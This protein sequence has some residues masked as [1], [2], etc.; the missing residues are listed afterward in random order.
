VFTQETG[1]IMDIPLIA[2]QLKAIRG[3]YACDCGSHE[4]YIDADATYD[5]IKPLIEH[6]LFDHVSPRNILMI[7]HT[8]AFHAT[9]IDDI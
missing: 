2:R 1:A 4:T 5:E 9:S 8:I 7:T 6:A 3:T